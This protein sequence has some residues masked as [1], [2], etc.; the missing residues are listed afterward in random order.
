MKPIVLFLFSTVALA[1]SYLW[2][3]APSDATPDNTVVATI[4]GKPLTA[5]EWR[6]IIAANPA[7]AQA[8]FLA[9]GPDALQQLALMR[10]LATI[11]E[12]EHVDQI[13]PWKEQLEQQRMQTLATAKLSLA[14]TA[15]P[16]SAEEQKKFYDDYKDRLYSQAKV[17]I[18][19]VAFSAN[20]T[21]KVP[22][23]EQAKA[24]IEKLLARIRK[25]ADFVKLV[26]ENSDD[27][28]SKA[29]DGDFGTPIQ[30]SDNLPPEILKAIFGLKQGEVSDPIKT[31]SGFYLYRLE[32]LT[33]QPYEQA[34][35]NIFIQ[36]QQIKFQKWYQEVRKTVEVKI[37][38]PEFFTPP[39]S[40][41]ASGSN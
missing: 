12:E 4:G 7:D 33:V 30:R 6:A 22:S 2:A 17:K 36:I 40:G 24:K 15:S 10:K 27:A 41:A 9:K 28:D 34:K 31:T 14:Q 16:V 35:D 19:Y 25:G 23:E 29:H 38:K 21:E 20:P 3:Q 5:G 39:S 32:E 1:P 13:S 11:A 8:Y 37:T 26:K 18:L